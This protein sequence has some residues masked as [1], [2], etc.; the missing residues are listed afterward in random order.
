MRIPGITGNPSSAL[1]SQESQADFIN[2]TIARVAGAIL[3]G[4]LLIV[5]FVYFGIITLP[6]S[7]PVFLTGAGFV[8]AVAASAF[9]CRDAKASTE[10]SEEPLKEDK[11]PLV[12][13]YTAPDSPEAGA[14]IESS[15]DE[16]DFGFQLVEGEGSGKY[17][18][19]Q[20]AS[21]K[22]AIDKWKSIGVQISADPK[23]ALPVLLDK[24]FDI[25]LEAFCKN[26]NSN[27]DQPIIDFIGQTS[28]NGQSNDIDAYEWKASQKYLLL[29][30]GIE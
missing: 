18:F 9:L 29:G 15:D 21:K 13:L 2:Q 16:K 26:Q 14:G 20:E 11:E 6:F 27:P 7:W 3:A 25:F 1:D 22:A 17:E 24:E 10:E 4:D 8:G 28:L 12:R 5:G 23:M 30:L 19:R